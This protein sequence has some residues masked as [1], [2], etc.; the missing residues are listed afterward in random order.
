MKTP[1]DDIINLPHPEPKRRPRMARQERAAQFAPFAAVTEHRTVIKN[2]ALRAREALEPRYGDEE[3][4]SYQNM[5]ESQN[6]ALKE[7]VFFMR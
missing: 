5:S 3:W 7:Y 6:E 2:T 4:D 1:Y